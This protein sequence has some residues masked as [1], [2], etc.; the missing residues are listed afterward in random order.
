MKYIGLVIAIVVAMAAGF[1]V[2]QGMGGQSAPTDQ[3][4]VAQP[5]EPAIKEI[6]VYAAARDIPIGTKIDANML[7]TLKWPEHLV[8]DGFI[9]AGDGAQGVVGK[10]ARASFRRDEPMNGSKLI[11]PDD[12]SFL[13]G[14]LP[15]GMR[16]VTI[17]TDE[18]DGV[19]GFIFPGDRVDIL[20]THRVLKSGVTEE[21]LQEDDVNQQDL[22]EKAT[23]TLLYNLRV[24]AVDQ[25][26]TGGADQGGEILVPGSVSLEVTPEQAQK[27]KLGADIGELS[28]ALRSLEEGDEIQTIAITRQSGISQAVPVAESEKKKK[29]SGSV[30][31]VRG[32]EVE[33]NEEEE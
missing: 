14:E 9:R 7:T 24:L 8:V 13:A 11:N 5:A 30:R 17:E 6:L 23:E 33:Q 10:V 21:E 20:V 26:A 4:V 32:T 16:V 25:R 19:A 1:L 29:K 22:M 28:L 31:V 3:V 12:P 15:R 18:I 2:L 27:L